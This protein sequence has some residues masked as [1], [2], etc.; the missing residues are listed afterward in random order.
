MACNNSRSIPMSCLLMK[1]GAPSSAP[2][3][4]IYEKDNILV[5]AKKRS[6]FKGETVVLLDCKFF[7]VLEVLFTLFAPILLQL[8]D[9]TIILQLLN[10]LI[11]LL[12][13]IRIFLTDIKGECKCVWCLTIVELITDNLKLYLTGLN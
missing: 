7:A 10:C 2:A 3:M 11:E 6:F 5:Y 1:S 8:I 12:N 13:D 9:R 4:C